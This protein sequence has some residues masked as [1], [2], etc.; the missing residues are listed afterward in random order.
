MPKAQ[1]IRQVVKLALRQLGVDAMESL[2]SHTPRLA[3]SFKSVVSGL[4]TLWALAIFAWACF[5]RPI[6]R[7]DGSQKDRLENVSNFRIP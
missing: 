3:S 2:E 1:R 7:G 6:E 4:N 5:F